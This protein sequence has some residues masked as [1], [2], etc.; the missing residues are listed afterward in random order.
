[1]IQV[2][3][4]KIW[5]SFWFVMSGWL[6]FDPRFL[7]PPFWK[8]IW[9]IADVTSFRLTPGDA[10]LLREVLAVVDRRHEELDRAPAEP[11]LVQPPAAERVRV[12]EREA[13]RRDVPV[14]R[15][16]RVA[17]VAVRQRGRQEPVRLLMAVP[18]EEP[19]VRAQVVIELE[20]ALIVLPLEESG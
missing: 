3:L 7:D 10:H 2:T 15:A 9:L 18:H 20:V 1:M 14:A 19:V 11:E 12:V 13:L 4:S 8:M 5:K 16:E 17:G 6:P